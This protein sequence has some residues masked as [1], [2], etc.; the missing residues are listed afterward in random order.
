MC[1]HLMHSYIRGCCFGLNEKNM[2]SNRTLNTTMAITVHNHLLPVY[3]FTPVEKCHK[4]WNNAIFG[5]CVFTNH[6]HSQS[7]EVY[8]CM[9][10]QLGVDKKKLKSFQSLEV[11][12]RSNPKLGVTVHVI[13][14][15]V[16]W[17]NSLTAKLF[18]LTF[19]PLEVVS[20]W[21]DPQL[22]VSENYS[23]LTKWR[24]TVFKYCWLMSHIIFNMFKRW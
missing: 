8:R 6:V 17:V 9:K 22:Q 2:N 14:I 10:I 4:S 19:H 16:L 18:N 11:V 13:L 1:G 23:D 24:L 7:F 15:S 20:R 3:L 21:R 5:D 12:D